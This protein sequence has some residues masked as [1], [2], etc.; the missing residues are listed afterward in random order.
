RLRADGLSWEAVAARVERSVRTCR[1]W[2]SL[3]PDAW[4][5]L[6]R[7]AVD[8]NHAEASAEA[9]TIL[10]TLLRSEEEKTRLT[11]AQL[12]LKS[13]SEAR[14][15]K[16]NE[17]TADNPPDADTNQF[18]ACLKDLD[19]AQLD[20]IVDY[21]VARRRSAAADGPAGTEPAP[22]AALSE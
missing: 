9:L 21:L 18:L 4:G 11:A 14:R 16:K 19:D 10:R 2:P 17:D 20:R 15:S 8:D 22:V 13:Q 3:Y 12:L 7:D 5:R 1:G 6:Y